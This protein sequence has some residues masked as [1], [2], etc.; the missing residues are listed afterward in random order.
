MRSIRIKKLRIEHVAMV[1][2]TA[3]V[4][5]STP[6][7]EPPACKEVVC[8]NG[9]TCIDG[10][11]QCPNGFYG[12]SCSK[13]ATWNVSGYAKQEFQGFPPFCMS[14]YLMSYS[15]VPHNPTL[16]DANMMY[17]ALD[18]Y[19]GVFYQRT[20]SGVVKGD[21]VIFNSVSITDTTGVWITSGYM[22]GTNVSNVE[23][24]YNYMNANYSFDYQEGAQTG[25]CTGTM[26]I[27][28]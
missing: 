13:T 28:G 15:V 23:G 18:E 8:S 19:T 4:L 3:W 27:G 9:G 12:T 21:S 16:N 25:T 7:C 22:V 2:M 5:L 10:T 6:S 26:A 1:C 17:R 11:C 14:G 24:L 20:L